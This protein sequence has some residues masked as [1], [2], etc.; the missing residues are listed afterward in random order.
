MET[1]LQVLICTYGTEGIRRVAESE[2]PEVNGVEYLVS[3]QTD[4]TVEIPGELKRSDFI[5]FTT[6]TKGLSV[7]RNH[8]IKHSSAPLLLISD[9]DVAYRKEDLIRVMDAFERHPEANILT[10]EYMSS[11]YPK[12]YPDREFSLET[13]AKGYFVTSFEIALRRESVQGKIKFNEFF[14]IGAMF[15]SGEEDVFLKDCLNAGLRGYFIPQVIARHD[16]S[17]TSDRNRKSISMPQTKGAVFMH[18]FPHSWMMRMMMHTLRQYTVW[19]SGEGL[20]PWSYA[21]NWMRGAWLATRHKVFCK[22][23]KTG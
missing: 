1:K 12:S 13:P 23:S 10:F 15:P 8:A 3:W 14:G 18:L 7:N 9:D 20:S 22:E 4:G 21:F 17:T 11:G 5:V 2:H 19:K 6:P 16:G